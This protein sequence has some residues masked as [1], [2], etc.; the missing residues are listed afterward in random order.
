MKLMKAIPINPVMNIV[1]PKPF[2]PSGTLEY[3]SFSLIAAKAMIARK[4]P[5]PDPKPNTV[6]SPI[7]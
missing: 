1:I 7:E 6:A 4:K 2:K 5:I 3:L